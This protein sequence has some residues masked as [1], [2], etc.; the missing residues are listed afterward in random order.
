[1]SA[2]RG[3]RIKPSAHLSVTGKLAVR[4]P[5]TAAGWRRVQRQ[6]MEDRLDPTVSEPIDQHV[7]LIAIRGHEVVDVPVME[8]LRG[9][10][11]ATQPLVA[12]KRSQCMAPPNHA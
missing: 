8:T 12:L 4:V 3:S 11:W 5:V 10:R 6:V 1:M 7:T 2:H 9:H